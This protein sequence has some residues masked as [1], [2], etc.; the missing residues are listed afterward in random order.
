MTEFLNIKD[1]FLEI[2]VIGYTKQGES[3]LIILKSNVPEEK[4]V[5]SCV[6]DNYYEEVNHT[7]V[8]LEDIL[9]GRKLDLL[10]WSHPCMDH[11]K[12]IYEIYSKFCDCNS[13]VILPCALPNIAKNENDVSDNTYDILESFESEIKKADDCARNTFIYAINRQG[14]FTKD[15]IF[16]SKNCR[17]KVSILSPMDTS[18]ARQSYDKK[19]ENNYFSAALLFEIEKTSNLSRSKTIETLFKGIFGSDAEDHTIDFII[20]EY[21][22]IEDVNYVKIPHHGSESSAKFINLIGT[23]EYVD[24]AYEFKIGTTTTKKVKNQYGFIPSEQLMEKYKKKLSQVW[25]TNKDIFKAEFNSGV[26]KT[27]INLLDMVGE[28]VAYSGNA[29]EL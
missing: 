10:C 29:G 5:F 9:K 4:V 19:Y 2:Y 16:D 27:T 8:L 13:K 7:E 28:T 11:S 14:F 15:Y 6:I 1:L 20:N 21:E 3:V 12:G 24:G 22:T 26:I 25:C 23:K 17:L 18:I